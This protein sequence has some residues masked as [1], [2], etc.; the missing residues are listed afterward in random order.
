MVKFIREISKIRRKFLQLIINNQKDSL[1]EI[2][3]DD[4]DIISFIRQD[5]DSK[6]IFIA[7]MSG[8]IKNISFENIIENGIIETLFEY[9]SETKKN[10][11]DEIIL[12]K[13]GIFIGELKEG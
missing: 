13:Y 11:K 2:F 4:W 6:L 5:S 7:N 10:H 12:H 9:N 8:H 3:P 1:I